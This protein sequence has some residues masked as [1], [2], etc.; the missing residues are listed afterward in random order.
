MEVSVRVRV[1]GRDRGG[2]KI[3]KVEY[4]YSTET[5]RPAIN[6]ETGGD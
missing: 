3:G 5:G 4:K 2:K 1:V 6:R